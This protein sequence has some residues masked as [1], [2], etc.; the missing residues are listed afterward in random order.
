MIRKQAKKHNEQVVNHLEA[1]TFGEGCKIEIISLSAFKDRP[2]KLGTV[3]K[4]KVPSEEEKEA[5]RAK[6][7]VIAQLRPIFLQVKNSF[8]P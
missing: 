6:I 7:E 3:K 8:L 4:R 1:S 2:D 5:K